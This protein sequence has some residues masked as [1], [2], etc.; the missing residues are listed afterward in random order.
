MSISDNQRKKM[1]SA[2]SKTSDHTAKQPKVMACTC[3]HDFQD[4]RY[5]TGNRLH[6]PRKM[7]AYACTVCGRLKDL[8]G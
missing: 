1:K 2:P 6:N 8:K 7:G 5:G 3:A 4:Q